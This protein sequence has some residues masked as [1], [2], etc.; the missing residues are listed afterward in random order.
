LGVPAGPNP[1][2][3][4]HL[5]RRQAIRYKSSLRCGLFAAILHAK[6][7][8]EE[9]AKKQDI[10]IYLLDSYILFLLSRIISPLADN[11]VY[12]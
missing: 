4:E 7:I 11:S 3:K 12:Q 2:P 6:Q 1:T 8:K 10:P 9:R 5:G